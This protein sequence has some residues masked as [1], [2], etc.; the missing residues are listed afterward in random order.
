MRIFSLLGGQHVAQLTP[1]EL[2]VIR[3]CIDYALASKDNINSQ[4][5]LNT[6]AER[7][8]LISAEVKRVLR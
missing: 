8:Q 1:A 3:D 2:R 6:D 4:A 5:P 7:A